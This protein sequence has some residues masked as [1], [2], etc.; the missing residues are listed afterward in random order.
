MYFFF[1]IHDDKMQ[2]GVD[3]KMAHKVL[4]HVDN[5]KEKLTTQEYLNIV[6]SIQ[7]A[8][9]VDRHFKI[10][11]S[12]TQTYMHNTKFETPQLITCKSTHR[13]VVCQSSLNE[14]RPH[15]NDYYTLDL[16]VMLR[17]S[18]LDKFF[19]DAIKSS[20]RLNGISLWTINNVE[21]VS[22]LFAPWA[23]IQTKSN[24]MTEVVVFECKPYDF[25]SINM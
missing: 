10:G 20:L 8:R 9:D 5:I 7:Q 23:G 19:I 4:E 3:Y 2:V 21:M 24:V 16:L 25:L 22:G 13:V 14:Y 1:I 18:S 6:N 15:A 11:Y 17:H 12:V